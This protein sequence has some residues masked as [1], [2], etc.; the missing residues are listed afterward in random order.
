[1]APRNDTTAV[2]ARAPPTATTA[3]S[4]ETKGALVTLR[5]AP[6]LARG[7]RAVTSR[8]ICVPTTTGSIA[9]GLRTAVDILV[10]TTSTAAAEEVAVAVGAEDAVEV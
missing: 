6:S 1:M 5:H 10:A 9:T 3:R 4:V 2:E 8:R 7:M